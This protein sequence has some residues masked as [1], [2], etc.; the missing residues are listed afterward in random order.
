MDGFEDVILQHDCLPSR[1]ET[2]RHDVHRIAQKYGA[3]VHM[4]AAQSY[5]SDLDTLVRGATLGALMGNSLAPLVSL[6][7]VLANGS[8][9]RPAVSHLNPATTPSERETIASGGPSAEHLPPTHLR[10]SGAPSER[11]TIAP[12]SPSGEK[13]LPARRGPAGTPAE[14]EAVGP[15]HPCA[16]ELVGEMPVHRTDIASRKPESAGNVPADVRSNSES[17][18]I[19]ISDKRLSETGP[20]PIDPS[21]GAEISGKGVAETGKRKIA[22]RE[23]MTPGMKKI[24][25][26]PPSLEAPNP[27]NTEDWALW[28]FISNASV[29][30]DLPPPGDFSS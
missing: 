25:V 3:H 2:R 19:Q 16:H 22:P 4:S 24:D 13:L 27:P 21:S 15:D 14:Q 23:R 5:L 8:D 7:P 30:I 26:V 20:L 12:G 29:G 28:S 11:R 1:V 9:S 10:P 17:G 18:A 6:P